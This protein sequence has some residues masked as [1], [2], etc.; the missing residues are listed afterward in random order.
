MIG[1]FMAAFLVAVY[2]VFKEPEV[3]ETIEAKR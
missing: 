2:N 3:K 1:A